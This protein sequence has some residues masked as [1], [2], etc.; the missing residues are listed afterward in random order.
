MDKLKDFLLSAL[1]D[2]PLLPA[3]K[4]DVTCVQSIGLAKCCYF[5]IDNSFASSTTF[6]RNFN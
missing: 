4:I 1:S 6:Y 2:N 3:G 5:Y